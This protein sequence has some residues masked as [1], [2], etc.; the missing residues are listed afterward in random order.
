MP[1]RRCPWRAS[2]ACAPLPSSRSRPFDVSSSDLPVSTSSAP[3]SAPSW[4]VPSVAVS[5]LLSPPWPSS[6]RRGSG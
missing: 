5:T 1:R 2:R 3:A 6:S 4:S